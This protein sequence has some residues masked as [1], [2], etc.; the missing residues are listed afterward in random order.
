MACCGGQLW[1]CN[2][3]VPG[4]NPLITGQNVEDP[5]CDLA[6]ENKFK[7]EAQIYRLQCTAEGFQHI[8]I[9]NCD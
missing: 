4:L 6:V 9:Q 1:A 3:N 2:A 7:E 8:C 5:A